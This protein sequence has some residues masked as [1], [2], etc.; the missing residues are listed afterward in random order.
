[1]LDDVELNQYMEES[2]MLINPRDFYFKNKGVEE[3][4][5]EIVKNMFDEG[6]FCWGYC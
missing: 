4:K 5:M 2:Q 3:G 6:V 1:M